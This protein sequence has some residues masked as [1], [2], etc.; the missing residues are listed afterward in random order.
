MFKEKT[1][2]DSYS[3]KKKRSVARTKKKKTKK[4]ETRTIKKKQEKKKTRINTTYK[5]E[6]H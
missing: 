4:P 3:A 5:Q 2:V 6:D 1:R